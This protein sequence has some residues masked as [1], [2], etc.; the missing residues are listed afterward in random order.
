MVPNP[1]ER[2]CPQCGKAFVVPYAAY[3][4]T[5]CD[6][7]CYHAS[8]VGTGRPIEQRF[9][10]QVDKNG[11]VPTNRPDLG[12]CWVWTGKL[13]KKSHYAQL[14]TERE[15]YAHRVSYELLIGPI[16]DGLELDHLC[17]NR[18]CVN[19]AHLEPVTRQVNFLRGNH[20]NAIAIRTGFCK[21]GHPR[22]PE[23]LRT[24]KDGC[25]VCRACDREKQ[26]ERY[27]NRAN[28]G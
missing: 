22:T 6:A 14:N 3:S 11:P 21:R 28:N 20:P 24:N 2:V 1:R 19:P 12:P 16:P 7:E 23:N 10:E 18:A 27:R 8:R 4:K 5:Y 15:K 17:Q 13:N 9:W 26:R 25:K